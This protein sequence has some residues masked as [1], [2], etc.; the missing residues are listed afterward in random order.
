MATECCLEV[1]LAGVQDSPQAIHSSQSC[2]KA[3]RQGRVWRQCHFI[4]RAHAGVGLKH[5]TGDVKKLMGKVLAVDQN[6]Y[7][8]MLGHTCIINA[9][10]FFK[11]VFQVVK[12]MLDARTQAKI[13]VRLERHC[14]CC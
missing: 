6:H 1:S 12:P 14:L 4:P 2:S 10:S 13:E 7:P 5:L 3:A 11:M 8:E 9:P